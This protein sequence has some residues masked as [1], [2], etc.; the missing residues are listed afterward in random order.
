MRIVICSFARTSVS[1]SASADACVFSAL[2]IAAWSGN[3]A[4]KRIGSNAF[5]SA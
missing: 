2:A 4:P 1:A 5:A 3:A